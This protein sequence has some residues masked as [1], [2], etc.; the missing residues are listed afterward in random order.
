MTF[1]K[2]K[3]ILVLIPLILL[4]IS[5]AS[6]FIIFTNSCPKTETVRFPALLGIDNSTN[7]VSVTVNGHLFYPKNFYTTA[8]PHPVVVVVHG[9]Q[10]DA[11][12]DLRLVLE[13]TKRGFFA[14]SIDL[15]GAGHSEGILRP[16]FWKAAV[17]TIDYIYSRPDLF[18]LTRVGMVGHSMG[19]WTTFLASSWE[20]GHDNRLNC[21]V[22]WAGI[23]N[24]TKFK[25]DTSTMGGWSNEIGHL[26]VDAGMFEDTELV[27]NHNPLNYFIGGYNGSQPRNLLIIHGLN[28]AVVD[29]QQ[30]IQANNT[31]TNSSLY[32][33]NDDHLLIFDQSVIT[34]SIQWFYKYLNV[35]DV[36]IATIQAQGFTYVLLYAS[37]IFQLLF[38]FLTSFM[39]I[40]VAFYQ[41]PSHK[42]GIQVDEKAETTETK[43]II[44][45]WGVVGGAIAGSFIVMYLLADIIFN[46]MITLLI[47][48][49]ILGISVLVLN[50]VQNREKIN[51]TEVKNQLESHFNDDA[52]VK[53]FVVALFGIFA[54]FFVANAFKLVLYYPLSIEYYL[55]SILPS[56]G[57]S[58]GLEFFLRKGIQDHL[59]VKGRH[60][61]RLLMSLLII[62]FLG[63]ILLSIWMIYLTALA[64]GIS[65]LATSLVSTYIYQKTKNFLA[66]VL[67]QTVIIA[68]FMA[69]CY[70]FFLL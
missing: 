19:G 33:A 51:G 15:P 50:L 42:Q 39:L 10:V 59:P 54:Y 16:Y 63:A 41:R 52:F 53:V 31:A 11:S 43:Q 3:L 7:P 2:K 32:W 61:V 65:L 64:F 70:F 21:S 56:L 30:A 12:T 18:D 55:L 27:E 8:G 20:A 17:G 14:L 47:G 23:A 13:L 35:Q 22:T 26:K 36:D 44:L 4:I 34:N 46:L 29:P 60:W 58:L 57:I 40:F 24:T 62:V 49:A 38:I 6:S 25:E 67:F 69:N 66:S 37:C 5:S 48:A 68:F 28:D 9:F 45:K 1:S